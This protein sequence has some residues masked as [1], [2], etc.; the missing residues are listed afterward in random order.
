VP[1]PRLLLVH[2]AFHGA[3]CWERLTPQLERLGISHQTLDLPFT[4]TEDDV[5]AV[6]DA[7]DRSDEDVTVLGHS[8]G[9]A[10]ISAA[11]VQRGKPYGAVTSLVYLTAF[12]TAPGQ[13]VDFSG[14]PGIAKIQFGEIT[15]SIDAEAARSVFYH[16]CSEED[17]DWAAAHLREMPTSVLTAPE[18]VSPAWMLLPSTYIICTDDQILSVS[19]QEEMA[20]HAN[21][22][23]WIDS[24]HS[25]FLSC[26]TAL[27]EVLRDVILKG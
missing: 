3:W 2:G 20:V 13:S 26:P 14:A 16:R 19:A 22:T 7:V 21:R 4:S 12:M 17:A 23:M 9:G 8:F 11:A 10:V 27:A 18:P 15:A 6:R 5:A 24:D 1:S 25:P